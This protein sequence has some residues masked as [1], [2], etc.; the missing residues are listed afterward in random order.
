MSLVVDVGDIIADSR[1][2]LLSVHKSW[3]RTRLGDVARILNG[4]AFSSSRFSKTA[5]TPLIRIR[6][7]GGTTTSCRYDGEYD[8]S[9]LIQPGTLL[10]GMDG[11]FKASRWAGPPALLNQRVCSIKVDSR[12]YEP[13][14]LE[15]VLPGYLAAIHGETS[16]QTVKHL[17]SRSVAEIPLPL[18]PLAE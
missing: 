10:V 13:R 12:F 17:S 9:Y 18:P 4:F 5:G 2:P 7:V 1:D 11:E 8:A 15:L 16:S 14:L 3:T 6:D